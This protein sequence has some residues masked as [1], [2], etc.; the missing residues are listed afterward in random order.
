[1][2][3]KRRFKFAT[4]NVKNLAM[5]GVS[6]YGRRVAEKDYRPK[7]E[8]TGAMIRNLDAEFIGFQEM[9]SDQA[10]RDALT[11]ANEGRKR[12]PKYKTFFAGA[13]GALART[14]AATT[15]P[16]IGTPEVIVDFPRPITI[17]P[18]ETEQAVAVTATK[19][20]RPVLKITV[21][22]RG[23]PVTVFIAHLKSK[24]PDFR[25][26][27]GASFPPE[28]AMLTA[29]LYERTLGSLRAL[30]SRACEA[31]TLRLL[32][33]QAA[34]DNNTPVIV[35]GDLNDSEGAVTTDMIAGE[36]PFRYYTALTNPATGKRYTSEEAAAIRRRLWDVKLYSAEQIQSRRSEINPIYTHIYNGRYESLDHILVSQEFYFRN[37]QRLGL[38]EYLHAFN[39]FLV[40]ESIGGQ[41]INE[42]A[43]DHAPLV[44]TILMGEEAD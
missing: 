21:D 42:Y 26:P 41:P 7:V 2:P 19:F 38:L 6:I 33:N 27:P 24:R 37:N 39:D 14:A 28:E 43:S 10:L 18:A 1:M 25:L 8:W 4:F 31:A 13:D 35:L 29:D 32:V 30:V 16:I 34:T 15:L 23:T 12:P 9:W 44:A 22:V 17:V 5:P 11:V 20:R 40:D 36:E 3:T